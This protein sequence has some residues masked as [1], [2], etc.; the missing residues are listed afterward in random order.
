MN[1][2]DSMEEIIPQSITPVS[3]CSAVD[4]VFAQMVNISDG[5][6]V[7]EPTCPVCDSTAREDVEQ[8][9]LNTKDYK[10]C[11]KMF[12]DLTGVSVAKGALEN[13]MRFH[14]DR[15]VKEQVKRE[16][17]DRVKRLTSTKL[18]TVDSIELGMAT[19]L[20]R[21]FAMNCLLPSND[22]DTES[23]EKTKSAETAKL[24]AQWVSLIK[25]KASILG[26][27]KHTGEIITIPTD[28][29]IKIFNYAFA[30]AQTE[31]ETRLVKGIM[32]RFEKLSE[33]TQ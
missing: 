23:F 24:M 32:L 3:G 7:H 8:L 22:Q 17:I 30:E 26:E 10:A 5:M 16:Y 29:F 31:K 21:L 11:L 14:Y 9:F 20:E 12:K 6:V 25:L 19:I 13:H 4:K 33:T 15:G 2:E 18:T 27:M 1:Q 28:E